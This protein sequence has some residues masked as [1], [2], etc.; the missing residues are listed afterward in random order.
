MLVMV[1]APSAL[2][3]VLVGT[4]FGSDIRTDWSRKSLIRYDKMGLISGSFLGIGV[5][6]FIPCDHLPCS[7]NYSKE[8][9]AVDHGPRMHS[10]HSLTHL[11][12]PVRQ[13]SVRLCC[14]PQSRC[15]FAVGRRCLLLKR[16]IYRTPGALPNILLVVAGG[17]SPCAYPNEI[18]LVGS[19]DLGP[20]WSLALCSRDIH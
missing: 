18:D 14:F 15:P 16:S 9:L 17:D 12:D 11:W 1:F 2:V 3:L 8:L 4:W 10:P 5:P 20:L 19:R 13:Q 7:S 6:P